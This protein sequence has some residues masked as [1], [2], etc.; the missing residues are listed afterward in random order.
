MIIM[1]NGGF[2]LICYWP[3][4]NRREPSVLGTH[5][6]LQTKGVPSLSVSNT[7]KFIFTNE[8]LNSMLNKSF[9]L[10]LQFY[11]FFSFFFFNF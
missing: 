6:G 5:I 4:I 3:R 10:K 8:G 2:N 1:R 9:V 7:S 11:L